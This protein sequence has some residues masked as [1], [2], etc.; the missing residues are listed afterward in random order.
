[1][2][3][4]WS[5]SIVPTRFPIAGLLS[6]SALPYTDLP[7][8]LFQAYDSTTTLPRAERHKLGRTL[9]RSTP[10]FGPRPQ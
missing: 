1:M 9:K 10:P 3:H 4:L 6:S 8:R 7:Q 5:H 2:R